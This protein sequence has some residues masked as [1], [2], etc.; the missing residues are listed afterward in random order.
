MPDGRVRVFWW[1][2]GT[3]AANTGIASHLRLV[4][5]D[6][7]REPPASVAR[8]RDVA[9][10][11]RLSVDLNPDDVRA[12]FAVEVARALEGG[13]AALLRPERRRE[14]VAGAVDRGLREFDANLVIAVVQDA[15]RRRENVASP[16]VR[17]RL[18]LVPGA[19]DEPSLS[20]LIGAAGAVALAAFVA[21]MSWLAGG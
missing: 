8:R 1:R 14:L 4:G 20:W 16:A 3:H 5:I 18:S 12:A 9:R 15:A 21:M 10:E 2:M 13:P 19:A 11:N 6:D 17:S 7:A